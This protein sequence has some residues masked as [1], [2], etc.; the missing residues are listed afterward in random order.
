MI[1]LDPKGP[2]PDGLDA[3]VT[4]LYVLA[5]IGVPVMGYVYMIVDFRA[6]VRS[7][8]RALVR[9]MTYVSDAPDWARPFTPSSISALGL[10]M[11]C[12]E[13]D[14]W[15]AYRERVKELH[16]DRGGDRRSFLRFQAQFEEALD[17]LCSR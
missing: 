13:A 15:R 12:T 5:I 4:S 9:A 14:L 2:W 8:R 11:P 17:Y 3:L 10:T 6:Y 7:L 1:N 16:P